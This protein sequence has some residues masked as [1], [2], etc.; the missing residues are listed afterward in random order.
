MGEGGGRRGKT[1]YPALRALGDSTRS[2]DRTPRINPFA[3]AASRR[4]RAGAAPVAPAALHSAEG[5]EK[6]GEK[7]KL[8]APTAPTAPAYEDNA[9]DCRIHKEPVSDAMEKR[10][11]RVGRMKLTRTPATNHTSASQNIQLGQP[12]NPDGKKKK[13][14]NA[15]LNR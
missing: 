13:H 11:I 6:G 5:G 4:S 8:A 12:I 9:N 10:P 15:F 3:P 7:G 1:G 14:S 2:A